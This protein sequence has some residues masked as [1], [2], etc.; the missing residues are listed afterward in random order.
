MRKKEGKVNSRMW[1]DSINKSDDKIAR[2][3][4]V[5]SPRKTRNQRPEIVEN[6]GYDVQKDQQHD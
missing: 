6:D 4:F 1:N 5:F 2:K 3:I